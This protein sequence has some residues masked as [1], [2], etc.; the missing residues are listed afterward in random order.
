VPN[1]R[2]IDFL[3]ARRSAVAHSP[4]QSEITDDLPDVPVLP[5]TLLAMELERIAEPVDLR[6]FNDAVLGDLGATIQILR[7]IAKEHGDS[8]DRPARFEDCIADLGIEECV[9]A[10]ANGMLAGGADHGEIVEVWGH[11][12]EIARQ[13]YRLAEERFGFNPSQAYLAGLLH[14]IGALPSILGWGRSDLTGDYAL[15]ALKMAVLWGF[16]DFLKD[17]FYEAYLPGNNREWTAMMTSAHE[18]ASET[19]AWCPLNELMI[20]TPARMRG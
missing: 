18:T 16:P 15:C 14:D 7:L 20:R 11:S 4:L 2:M 10:V 12:T 8:N 13:C 9:S 6:R 5:E 19:W 17:Y 1:F 3:A